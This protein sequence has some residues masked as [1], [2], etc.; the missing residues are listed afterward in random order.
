MKEL[1]IPLIAYS[2]ILYIALPGI[3]FTIILSSMMFVSFESF[4][5]PSGKIIS[6]LIHPEF[7]KAI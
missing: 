7:K 2:S 1:G 4:I 3:S 5:V 6:F